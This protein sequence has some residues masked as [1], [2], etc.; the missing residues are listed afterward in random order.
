[1][2]EAVSRVESGKGWTM[3]LGDC[4]EVMATLG[5]SSSRVSGSAL[6]SKGQRWPRSARGRF[7]CSGD[8]RDQ[9]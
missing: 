9:I 2:E 3:H 5:T 4:L 8:R 7:R 6:R 1:M